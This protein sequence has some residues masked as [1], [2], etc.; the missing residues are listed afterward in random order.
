[1][2]TGYHNNCN[3]VYAYEFNSNIRALLLLLLLLLLTA[4]L[5]AP[6]KVGNSFWHFCCFFLLFL[7]CK[8][9]E[10]V[11]ADVVVMLLML[12]ETSLLWTHTLD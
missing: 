3:I 12:H 6:T 1:M 7:A 10:R 11:D 2:V 9:P 4:T 5:T 8:V